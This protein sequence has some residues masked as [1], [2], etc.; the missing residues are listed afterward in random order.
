MIPGEAHRDAVL[1]EADEVAYLD[2]AQA[3][4]NAKIEAYQRALTGIRAVERGK[5]PIK[6][7][8]P[9]LL[10]DVATVLIDCGLRPEECSRLRWEHVRDDA[11]HVPFGK[12]KN[13]RRTIPLTQRA[14]A[15]IEMRQ[16]TAR[17]SEWVFPANTKSGH[18]EKSSLKRQH[19]NACKLAEVTNFP[20]YTFRHTCL[21]RWAAFMDPYT[22]AYLAGH[23]DFST[24]RRY[25]HPQVQTIRDAMERARVGQGRHSSGHNSKAPI[26]SPAILKAVS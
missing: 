14:A 15:L 26:E 2:A 20:F 21:T 1:S 17:S 18:I 11:V 8:D 19:L 4:G 6:P 3:L 23:S 7:E 13:A 22:L 24:M 9:F 25:V 10:R 16:A 5:V 12:T